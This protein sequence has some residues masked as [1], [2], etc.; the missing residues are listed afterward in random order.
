MMFTATLPADVEHIARK[1]M[2]NPIRIQIGQTAPAHRARQELFEL[3]EEAKSPLLQKLLG[4]CQGRVL[5]FVRTKRGVDRLARVVM[6]RLRGVARLHS[7]RGQTERDAAMAGFREG[8][9]RILIATDIAARGLDVADIE[10]VINYDVPQSADDYLHRIGRTARVAASGR[11]TSFVTR[12]DQGL[13]ADLERLN[14]AR[15]PLR[16]NPLTAGP[17]PRE[18]ARDARPPRPPRRAPDRAREGGHPR[19]GREERQAGPDRSPASGAR[20]A[21][22][23]QASA[24][25]AS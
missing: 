14:G 9:Y 20:H 7:D 13:L 12:S 25:A 6:S 8:K 2:H 10:H 22:G 16:P 11:A 1:S 15:L 21:A 18:D 5:V 23:S 3:S 4:Q 17:A 19:Q 24:H